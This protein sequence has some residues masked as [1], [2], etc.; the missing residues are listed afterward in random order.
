[1]HLS[2]LRLRDFRNYGRLDLEFTPGLHLFLGN[3]A[4][5]K[6]NILEAIYILATLR[7]FRGV[8]SA[9]MVRHNQTGYFIGAKVVS[10]ASRE[11]K[12]YWSQRQRQLSVDSQPVRKLAE[13]I[14]IFRAVVFCSDDVLL[15]KG[16]ASRRRRFLDLILAQTQSTYLP[17]LQRY[18][19]ALR[20][21]NALLKQRSPDAYSLESFTEE[22]VSVGKQLVARRHAILP[23]VTPLILEAYQRVANAA[24][25]LRLDY[26]PSVRSD[27]ARELEQSRNRERVLKSTLIG[28]HRDEIVLTL[29]SK[30]AAQFAS[31][32]QKRSIAIALKIAQAE[33]LNM[34]FGAPPVLLIDDVMGELDSRRRSAFVP[35]L[36]RIH[37][38][39]SQVFMTC[40]EE[41]WPRDLARQARRYHVAAGSI[42]LGRGTA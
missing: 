31:E 16:P 30:P 42:N 39:N 37:R 11:I 20:S 10:Q 22:V 23:L 19:K 36:Q 32:G 1:V 18:A 12:I 33:Y 29:D 26:Q 7:S 25:E 17:L 40:T 9:Q 41:N 6:T 2:Q 4:Q 21:R 14:G 13:F 28:P 8:G 3:N 35:L 5:G 15:V 27:F 34:H 38:A 24:E